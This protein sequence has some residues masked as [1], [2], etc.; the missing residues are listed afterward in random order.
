MLIN[1]AKTAHKDILG[2]LQYFIDEND[3][4]T[5]QAIV[6][7]LLS[8]TERLK[9][10]PLSSRQGQIAGTRELVLSK[11]PYILIYHIPDS[12][13]VEIIRVVHTSMLWGNP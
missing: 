2:I 3:T 12:D 1:W 5:G 10:F 9:S 4:E 6:D 8:S 11:L 7:T 13:N